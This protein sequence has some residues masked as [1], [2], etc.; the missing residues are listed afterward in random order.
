MFGGQFC[1]WFPDEVGDLAVGGQPPQRRV[2]HV[3]AQCQAVILAD[4]AG[5]RAGGLV[6]PAVVQDVRQVI[7]NPGQPHDAA[8]SRAF[9]AAACHRSPL[10]FQACTWTPLI[11]GLHVQVLIHGSRHDAGWVFGEF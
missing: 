1:T 9:D 10:Q 2:V 4:Q 5:P 7:L 8:Q 11:D 6:G 3:A